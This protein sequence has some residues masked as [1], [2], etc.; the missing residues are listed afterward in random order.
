[1]QICDNVNITHMH[2]T[3]SVNIGTLF[4]L[5]KV[6][7][8][9]TGLAVRF[10]NQGGNPSTRSWSLVEAA[11]LAEL[12]LLLAFHWLPFILVSLWQRI[13]SMRQSGGHGDT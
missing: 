4:F 2:I 12:Y 7:S 13:L 10:V 8:P 11:I 3:C 6:T 1:M 9:T 5:Y